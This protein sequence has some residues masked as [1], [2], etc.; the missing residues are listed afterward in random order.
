M[1]GRKTVL[2]NSVYY[3][4]SSF[5][6]RPLVFLLPLYGIYL[7]PSDY[8]ITNLIQSSGCVNVSGLFRCILRFL[9]ML[10]TRMILTN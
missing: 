10:N 3:T 6:L 7:T 1:S 5:L 8:G 2:A 9:F 4:V